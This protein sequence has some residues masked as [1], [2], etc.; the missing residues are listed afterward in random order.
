MLA[1]RPKGFSPRIRVEGFRFEDERV[2]CQAA[3][4]FLFGPVSLVRFAGYALRP[5]TKTLNPCTL[6]QSCEQKAQAEA[7]QAAGSEAGRKSFDPEP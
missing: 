6:G 5:G 3:W 4:G 1:S 7:N 2:H